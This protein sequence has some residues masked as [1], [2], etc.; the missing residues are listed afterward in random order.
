MVAWKIFSA[1][2]YAILASSHIRIDIWYTHDESRRRLHSAQPF[3]ACVS[4]IPLATR[5]MPFCFYASFL[6]DPLPWRRR[7]RTI[8]LLTWRDAIRQCAKKFS[9]VK[10]LIHTYCAVA[11]IKI[12]EWN[13]KLPRFWIY[14][15]TLLRYV[16]YFLFFFMMMMMMMMMETDRVFANYKLKI[17]AALNE[18]TDC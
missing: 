8:R 4:C 14:I 7:R 5:W 10:I 2:L 15:P 13:C 9:P 11:Y 3:V 16:F 18:Y 12:K 6:F 17:I 1:K